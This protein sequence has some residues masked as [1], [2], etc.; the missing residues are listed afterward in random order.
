MN[1]SNKHSAG[2]F[3]WR[4]LQILAVD[5]PRLHWRLWRAKYS[6]EDVKPTLAEADKLGKELASRLRLAIEARRDKRKR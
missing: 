1:S 3:W 6:G 2:G 4:L 5:Y